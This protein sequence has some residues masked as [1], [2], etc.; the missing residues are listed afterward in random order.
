MINFDEIVWHDTE[1]ISIFLDRSAPGLKDVLEIKCKNEING[2][3]IALFNNVWKVTCDLNFGIVS[4]ETIRFVK[5]LDSDAKIESIKRQWKSV[6]M[7][8]GPL[9]AL[10]VETN[11][12]ASKI[13]VI[14]EA[15]EINCVRPI[16]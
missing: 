13:L 11:S 1:I 4:P 12:T 14:F 10:E 5:I 3:F 6:G 9:I 16:N 7:D 15:I 8:I 2:C